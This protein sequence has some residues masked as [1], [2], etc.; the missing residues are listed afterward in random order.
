LQEVTRRPRPR[1]GKDA[2]PEGGADVADRA[3]GRLL[4]PEAEREIR[5]QRRR[6]DA[7]RSVEGER[8]D[9]PVVEDPEPAAVPQNV[10]EPVARAVAPGDQDR[11]RALIRDPARRLGPVGLAPNR[12][13]GE[14]R[15]LRQVR[16]HDVAKGQEVPAKGPDAVAGKEPRPAGRREDRVQ[17]DVGRAVAGERGCDGADVTGVTEHPDLHRRRQE[18]GEDRVELLPDETGRKPLDGGDPAGV[19]GRAR[20]DD[21]RPVQAVRREGQEVRLDPGAAPRVGA[22]DGQ[23]ADR[24]RSPSGPH[25]ATLADGSLC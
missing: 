6:K 8:V 16:S 13:A 1:S 15:R 2:P 21:G 20:D 19:L 18:I 12:D 5:G 4:E 24:P 3:G 7:A 9:P 25:P 17:D 11:A 23:H 10:P 22:R 14:L